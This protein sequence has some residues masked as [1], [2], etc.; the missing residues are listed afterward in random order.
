MT[1]NSA[2][3]PSDFR[4]DEVDELFKL[5]RA[6]ESASIIGM[7]GTGK[8]NLFNHICNLETQKNYISDMDEM[9]IVLRVNFHYAPDFTD[10]SLYSLMM[11]QLEDLAGTPAEHLGIDPEI[12][13]QIA[14]DHDALIDAGSELLRVQRQF[15]RAIRRLM[16]GSKRK[17]VFLF[18]QFDE[19]YQDA[20]PRF[21]ANLRGLRESYKY[22]ISYLIFTRD[23]LPNLTTS[24]PAREEFYELL[25][26]NV[27]ALRPYN[28]RDARQLL[29]RIG[30]RNKIIFNE[31]DA[32][33]F[34]N[35]TG[36][37][38][39]MLRGVLFAVGRF[40]VMLVEEIEGVIAQLLDVASVR[41][42]CEKIWRS[43]NVQEQKVLH[44]AQH[45]A[46][47]DVSEQVIVRTLQL[48]GVIL[49]TV[50]L[51]VFSP[52]FAA[53][54]REMDPLWERPLFFDPQS[55]QV[56]VLGEPIPALTKLEY[57]LFRLLYERENEV[58]AKDELVNAGWP[59]AQGG[60]SD[61]ALTAAMARLRRK[62]EPDGKNPRF[63]EN[64][65]NQGYILRME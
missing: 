61:E 9:P 40:E 50:P 55:R 64:V 51:R 48:K 59:R 6:G 43:L 35:W 65:R 58:V 37:H 1:D 56:L 19:I 16:V 39:G 38:A 46:E 28:E 4:E 53:F 23:L 30:E 29:D 41:L 47:L 17:I 34:I 2:M 31:D 24:D 7:S 45:E 21:F 5:I 42:E 32:D 54:V 62:I 52:L 10:R 49:Q 44:R 12:I 27:L 18:D 57:R 13:E 8:S 20:E 14:I 22:R 60:V 36:G 33:Q 3:Q 26:P 25:A 63:F 11:E 15:K